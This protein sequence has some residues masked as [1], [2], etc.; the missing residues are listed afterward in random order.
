MAVGLLRRAVR[1]E[2]ANCQRRQKVSYKEDLKLV[3]SVIDTKADIAKL[4]EANKAFVRLEA[5]AKKSDEVL[6]GWDETIKEITENQKKLDELEEK[7]PSPS[8]VTALPNFQEASLEEQKQILFIIL[9][10]EDYAREQDGIIQ[11]EYLKALKERDLEAV[12]DALNR[13]NGI[14]YEF[15]I[16]NYLQT[17][18]L[19]NR[20][21]E[22]RVGKEC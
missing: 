4:S 2:E 18:L 15:A 16:L 5:L 13:H 10:S 8:F 11:D 3:E 14:K 22:R 17:A 20:S 12:V 1:Y 7:D 19:K 21:E 6:A 9:F